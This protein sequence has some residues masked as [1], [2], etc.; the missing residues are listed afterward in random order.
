M[1]L[2]ILPLIVTTAAFSQ[3]AGYIAD[4]NYQVSDIS[5]K[6]LKKE[7][8]FARME[9][10]MMDLE[11]AICANKAHVW[12]YDFYRFY[13]INTGKIFVFF[14]SSIW[15]EDKK[16]WMYHVAP[17]IVENGKEWVMEASYSDVL[18]PLDVNAWVANETYGRVDGSECVELSV[19]DTDLTHYFYERFNLPENRGPGKQGARC[20][21][22][23]VPGYYWFPTSI[24]M[25]ELKKD[26]DGDS[27]DFN[28][29][30]FDIDDVIKACDEAVSS[31][32]GRIFGG[33]K[34]KCKKYL[35]R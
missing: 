7:V 13:G 10:S 14:G 15:T 24:A 34:A 8:L 11:K 28:P 25:H 4:Y 35:K 1:K 22:K 18:K 27:I 6:G 31:K 21:L 12:A 33:A 29:T 16:G 23:K 20:Y 26:E 9:R 19:A 30:S 32:F 3:T 2:L 17:Y 5:E